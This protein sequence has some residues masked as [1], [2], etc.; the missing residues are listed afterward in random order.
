ML[1]ACRLHTAH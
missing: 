1:I